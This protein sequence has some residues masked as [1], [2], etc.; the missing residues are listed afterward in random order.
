MVEDLAVDDKDLKF[1]RELLT[2]IT[3]V[4]AELGHTQGLESL[5]D[6]DFRFVYNN[7]VL[8]I[9]GRPFRQLSRSDLY[10]FYELD[11]LG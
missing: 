6:S 5:E 1:V 4:F 9:L 8:I 10:L 2:L 7:W 11:Y 3:Y